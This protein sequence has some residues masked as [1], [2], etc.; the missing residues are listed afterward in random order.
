MT[1]YGKILH[2][3]NN[4]LLSSFF[5]RSSNFPHVSL[6]EKIADLQAHTQTWESCFYSKLTESCDTWAF[7]AILQQWR[8]WFLR[9]SC[10]RLHHPKHRMNAGRYYNRDKPKNTLRERSQRQKSD[11]LWFHLYKISRTGKSRDK[12]ISGARLRGTAQGILSVLC[13]V[14]TELWRGTGSSGT[15]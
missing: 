14:V 15:T 13:V 12:K 9:D 1:T 10:M 7:D 4:F 5:I 8:W 2:W 6:K 3:K 11:I